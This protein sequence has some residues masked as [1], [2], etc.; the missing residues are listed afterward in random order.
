MNGW[1]GAAIAGLV[2]FL[3]GVVNLIANWRKKL[4]WR[5]DAIRAFS[6]LCT[7][8]LAYLSIQ[9]KW[10]GADIAVSYNPLYSFSF[11]GFI[12][13]I[14]SLFSYVAKFITKRKCEASIDFNRFW[15]G[16]VIFFIGLI[17]LIITGG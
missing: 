11:A 8:L 2:L 7:L 14:E 1:Y 17:A 6:G 4:E 16:V 10:F 15:V 9:F 13:L 3:E 12:L 5:S